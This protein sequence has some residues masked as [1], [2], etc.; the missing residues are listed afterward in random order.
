MLGYRRFGW[1]LTA[2][3]RRWFETERAARRR[4]ARERREYFIRR[5]GYLLDK[6]EA[7]HGIKSVTPQLSRHLH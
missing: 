2:L 6:E 4:R 3:Y 5:E 1:R 7:A